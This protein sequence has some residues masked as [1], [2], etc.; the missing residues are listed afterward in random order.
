[1]ANLKTVAGGLKAR[2]VEMY[3]KQMGFEP[4]VKR[5]LA[6]LAENQRALE[7]TQIQVAQAL[8]QMTNLIQQF[9]IVAGRMKESHEDLIKRMQGSDRPDL[10]SALGEPE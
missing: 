8:D 4:G 9:S 3:I 2:D 10:P 6:E 1:M 5:C 7:H